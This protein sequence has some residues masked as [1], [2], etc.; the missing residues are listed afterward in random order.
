VSA[1]RGGLGLAVDHYA[2]RL[3]PF[4]L[5]VNNSIVFYV[6][7]G[8]IEQATS[9]HVERLT[10]LGAPLFQVGDRGAFL[11]PPGGELELTV[12]FR[13][14]LSSE[15]GVSSR[16]E[17]VTP[18]SYQFPRHIERVITSRTRQDGEPS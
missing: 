10:L 13:W 6:N 8:T 1:T 2:Q 11:I 14:G 12:R 3:Q 5:N 7:V 18:G 9:S 17:H 4:P 15:L 16:D